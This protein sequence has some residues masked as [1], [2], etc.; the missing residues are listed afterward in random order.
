MSEQLVEKYRPETFDELQGNNQDLDAIRDWAANWSPGDPPQL[1]VGPPGTGKTSTAY[2]TAD[3]FDW[4]LHE[5]NASAARTSDDIAQFTRTMRSTP[6]TADHQLVLVDEVDSQHSA[7]DLSPLYEELRDPSNPVILTANDKYEVPDP[8][9]S[10]A[11]VREFSLGVRSRKAKLKEIAE[12]E[13]IDLAPS[14]LKRL[15]ERPD[16]RS[17]I[18]DLQHV[19]GGGSAGADGR[20]WDEGEFSAIDALLSGDAETWRDALAADDDTFSR[21]DD[22]IL[23]ADENI[24]TEFRGLEQGVAY[25]ALA[26]ADE[27][28]GR[29]WERQEFRFQRY[30]YAFVEMLPETRLTEPYGGY[31]NVNFPSWFRSTTD[32][33]DGSSPE[34]AVY[35]ELKDERG[36]TFAGSYYEFKRRVYPI[37]RGLDEDERMELALDHDLSKDAIE[38]LGIDTDDMEAWADED[39]DQDEE[40][41][42][43]ESAAGTSW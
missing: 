8:I 12:A 30:A 29:A 38:A 14:E 43:A 2:V 13:G 42:L 39:I 21:P 16:L 6:T 26:A 3:T 35:Q 15:A 4:P 18:N 28:A 11:E 31:I 25:Q 22:A 27:W 5:I 1:L 24:T 9:T 36:F 7:V 40:P 17:A 37:L 33:P 34:A 20:T 41:Q 10:A 32:G 19:A 23:W